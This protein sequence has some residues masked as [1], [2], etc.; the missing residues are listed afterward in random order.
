MKLKI[1]KPIKESERMQE[2]YEKRL[3]FERKISELLALKSA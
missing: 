1:A 3:E 2:L